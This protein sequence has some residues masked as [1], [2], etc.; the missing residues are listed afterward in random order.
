[1]S[2]APPPFHLAIPVDDLDAAAAFYGTT[3]GFDRGRSDPAHWIDWDLH[4]HQ[5]VTHLVPG[6]ANRHAGYSFVDGHE[7]PVPHFGFVLSVDQ[8]QELASRLTSAG[9]DFIMQPQLRF[10]GL[11]GE[12]WTM[13]FLDPAGNAIEIKGMAD[14]KQLFAV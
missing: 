3:L 2:S 7:V 5:V 4:G 8:F 12:Q 10:P 11:P 6:V 14:L 1:M 9:I 13:F